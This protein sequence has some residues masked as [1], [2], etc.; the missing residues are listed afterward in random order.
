MKTS[1]LFIVSLFVLASFASLQADEGP[2]LANGIKI[3]EVDQ[4][5]A[6][7]WVRLTQD[8][9][10][11]LNGEPWNSK[12]ESVPEGKTIGDMEYSAVGAAGEARVTYWSNKKDKV[13]LDWAAV[14]AKR[15]F[16]TA[17]QLEGLSPW[18]E[19]SLK[20][21][22][23]A[24]GDLKAANEIRGKL[25]TAPVKKD[26]EAVTFAS[27]VSIDPESCGPRFHGACWRH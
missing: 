3:G 6:I 1:L 19:Y 18:T 26:A 27:R 16:T 11:N 25:K 13:V 8:A 15:N 14:D 5:S 17:I 20:V 22:T 2:F 24:P 12:A 7:V 21:E 9:T 4:H 23:R 10:Y